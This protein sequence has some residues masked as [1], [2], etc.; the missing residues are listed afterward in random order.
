MSRWLKHVRFKFDVF[1]F[2]HNENNNMQGEGIKN[3]KK[4]IGE[5]GKFYTVVE[6]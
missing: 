3:I 5:S 6:K 2:L 4:F 1:G